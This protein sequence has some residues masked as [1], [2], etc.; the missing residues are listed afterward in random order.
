LFE[1]FLG[2]IL[3]LVND[4]HGFPALLDLPEQKFADERD[5]SQ[6]V[7]SLDVE[8][9][10][11][12]DGLHQP[13]RV[14]R[15]VE[16]ERGGKHAVELFEQRAAQR[17]LARADLAG[18]LHEALALADAVKQVIIRFAVSPAVKQKTRVRRKVER[19]QFQSIVFQ[20]HTGFLAEIA[21]R[22]TKRVVQASRLLFPASR[23]KQ[24]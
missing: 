14:Q 9:E 16:D 5:G 7:A 1:Q 13:V 22:E 18:E 24:A 12:R 19:R 10:F 2:Q 11:S 15:R 21:P 20:I 3:R 8:A 6:P 17:R 23:R 4:E